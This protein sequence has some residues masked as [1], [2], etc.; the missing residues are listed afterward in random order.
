[1]FKTV[2]TTPEQ[3]KQFLTTMQFLYPLMHPSDKPSDI[4]ND[5]GKQVFSPEQCEYLDWRFTECYDIL[6][7]P[8]DYIL[9][10]V[11][12]HMQM[13]QTPKKNDVLA[14]IDD[15]NQYLEGNVTKK[16]LKVTLLELLTKF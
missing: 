14:T 6:P 5:Q 9:K 2:I 13:F 3:A 16:G 1:M 11:R 10:Q 8:C 15:L 4:V 7:D 12:P